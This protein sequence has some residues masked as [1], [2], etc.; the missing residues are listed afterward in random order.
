[1]AAKRNLTVDTLEALGARRLARLLLDVA[2]SDPAI[3]RRLRIE[4]AAHASPN[5]V[6]LEIGKNLS[7]IARG[8][9][10]ADWRKAKELANDVDTQREAIA[11]RIAAADPKAAYDLMWRLLDLASG[12]YERCDDSNGTVGDVFRLA[13]TDLGAIARAAQPDPME[14]ADRVFAAL[15]RNDYGQYDRLIPTLAAC[16]GA[17]G[18]AHLKTRVTEL[19]RAP[20]P[21]PAD[22][23]RKQIGWSLRG[24]IFA[25]E[26]A[27][28]SRRS[29]V[30]TAL[31]D[32]ADAQGDVEAFAAQYDESRRRFPKIA[33][34]IAKRLIAANRAE[35]ALRTLEAADAPLQGWPDFEWEDSR[36]DALESLGRKDDAQAARLKCFERSLVKKYLRDFLDRLPDFEDAE[37]ERKALDHAESFPDVLQ[38][39]AFLIAWKQ[40]DRAA[41]LVLA[42]A[43]AWDGNHYEVLSPSAE[44]LA[45]KHPLAATVLLRAMIGFTLAK[46]R[47]SRYRHAARHLAD[48]AGLARS[49]ADF[50][51]LPTHDAYVA[52]LKAAHPRKSGFWSLMAGP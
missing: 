12:V 7:R 16:L 24:P 15:Q 3:E 9:S 13:M 4:L 26:V 37:A 47:S 49:I 45:G 5:E 6:V 35:E 23:E 41:R 50:G 42:R 32:I 39:L 21:R 52:A 20:V 22:G 34:E 30:R 25:D 38:A 33:A 17:P 29:H 40:P 11:G 10:Y 36:I 8:R 2:E 44:A 31:M 51:A 1:M 43:T 18:L 28:S 19:S 48:C 46:A 27:E 14:L